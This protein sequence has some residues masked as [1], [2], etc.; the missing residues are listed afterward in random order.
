MKAIVSAFAIAG[1]LATSA[2]AIEPI[3]GSIT[4]GGQPHSRLQKAP[5]GSVV[6][7]E[8]YSGGNRYREIYLIQPDRSLKLSGRSLFGNS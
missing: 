6:T 8:F 3:P 7:H 2:L 1:L 4:Y 5:V